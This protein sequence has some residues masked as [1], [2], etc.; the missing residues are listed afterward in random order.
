MAIADDISV[1]VN[2]DIRYTGNGTT[3]YTVLAFKNYLGSLLDDAQA[4]GDDLADI[5][6]DTI[7]ER[8]TDEIL[9][10]NSP[11]NVD[12][13]LIEHIYDGSIKQNGGDDIYSGLYVVGVVEAGTE[14]IIV[15]DNKVLSP[16]WGSGIN[17]DPAENVIMKIMVKSRSGGAN[18]NNQKVRVLAREFGDGYAEFDVTLGLANSTAAIFTSNDLNNEKTSSTIEGYT[19][20]VNTEGFQ[21]LDIDGTGA[22]GQEFYSQWDIGTQTLNDG[23]ER[24]KWIQ[25][26]AEDADAGTDTGTDYTVDNGTI[27]GQGQEFSARAQNEIL[28]EMRFDLKI[29][30]GTPTGD[31]YAE[32]Y[33][34]DDASPAA[35]TGAVLA[36]S[37]VLNANRLTSS[38][39]EV[40][41][42]FT[43]EVTLTANQEYFAIIRHPDGAAG[44][45]ISIDGAAAG[46]HAGNRA[47]DTGT[48][49]GSAATDLGFT[50]KSCPVIH[51]I[52]G[53]LFR[54]ITYEIGYDGE[55]NG[56][57]AE[58]EVVCWGTRITFDG[59]SGGGVSV[60]DYV[61]IGASATPTVSKNGGKVLKKA[62]A[63]LTIAL[64]NI[65]GSILLDD[66]RISV[67]GDPTKYCL[68]NV[69]IAD[70]TKAGGEGILLALDDNGVDGELYLQIITGAAPVEDSRLEA[71]DTTYADATA[72]LNSRTVSPA[73][74]GQST[75]TNIIGA[76]GIGFDPNDIGS[77]DKFFDLANTQRTP[78]NNVTFTV[79]GLVA[80]EDRILVGPRTG[81]ALNKAQYT[82]LTTLS[83]AAEVAVS[84]TGAIQTETPSEGQT[85][86]T[87]LRVQCNSGVYKRQPYTSWSGVA[88]TIPSTNYT[89]DPATQPKDVFVAYI[90]VLADAAQEAFTA[91]H[92][93]N[94]DLLIRVRDGGATPIKT[95]ESS[96][97][98][99]GSPQTVTI[100]R[101]PDA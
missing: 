4:S 46:A 6:T 85:G 88:F 62:G 64:E 79:A 34:S 84:L 15:Q 70:D 39:Q 24:T 2:G 68:I 10:L 11:Y 89:G 44:H 1:A 95:V 58:D 52:A 31:I 63:I 19:S 41:F 49:A 43:D 57:F 69:T 54:G 30:A 37:E 81:S 99:T 66:D 25:K 75:G 36:T 61:M 45:Y 21:E 18:I 12:D 29:G 47:E 86:N 94:R 23:Y 72:V 5:T 20:I 98:F 38:Y 97:Q 33:D 78:P 53:E 27:L 77:S 82:L 13:T 60:G 71:Q 100:N 101:V 48:W 55:T 35:P 9:E 17:A 67:A 14:P 83:G 93:T 90:D 32:L 80:G 50:V 73:F 74:V 7:Y 76:Y 28:V 51:G 91:V 26:R 92:S 42:R 3:Y 40:I 8:S 65:A 96:A 87:R 59:E 56:P 22:A 16:Y